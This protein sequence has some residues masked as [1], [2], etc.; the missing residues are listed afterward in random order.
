[1]LD[2]AENFYR[3][4]LCHKYP[5]AWKRRK[6]TDYD[7]NVS[8]QNTRVCEKKRERVLKTKK[9]LKNNDNRFFT[10]LY[11]ISH[12]W[13]QT[14][15]GGGRERK[16]ARWLVRKKKFL[17]NGSCRLSAHNLNITK[18]ILIRH[19][20]NNGGEKEKLLIAYKERER[21]KIRSLKD[22]KEIH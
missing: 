12:W 8:T 3:H 19:A 15:V 10:I 9:F 7:Q 17:L 18:V 16:Q 6:W 21:R 20:K 4:S 2:D 14:S 11:S 5:V 13:S 22:A 1:M